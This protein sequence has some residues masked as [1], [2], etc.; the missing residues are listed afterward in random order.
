MR[1][2]LASVGTYSNLKIEASCVVMTFDL[3]A[4]LSFAITADLMSL[5]AE[6]VK[7]FFSVLA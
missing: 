1:V 2:E 5:W 4:T 7:V 3:R 6:M